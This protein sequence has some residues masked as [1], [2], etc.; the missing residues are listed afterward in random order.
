MFDYFKPKEFF[1][2]KIRFVYDGI[3]YSGDGVLFWDPTDGFHVAV[4]IKREKGERQVQV[5]LRSLTFEASTTLYLRMKNGSHVILP[6]YF[7]R[8]QNLHRGFL[9]E[10]ARRAIII[11]RVPPTVANVWHGS[12]LY[13]LSGKITLPD[14]VSTEFKID[15]SEP[16]RRVSLEGIHHNS[17]TGFQVYGY[18]KDD[19]YLDVSWIMPVNDWTKS[20]CWRYARGLQH[21][22]SVLAGQSIEL[23]YREVYRANRRYREV[24]LNQS[25]IDLGII[26]R[27]FDYD[28]LDR[29]D[30][31]NLAE[32]FTCGGETAEYARR[33]F[34]QMADASKQRSNAGKELLISTILEA[35]LRSIYN[36]PFDPNKNKKE[37]KFLINYYLKQFRTDYLVGSNDSKRRWKQIT[38]NVNSVYEILRHRNAHPDWKSTING[39][40]SKPELE[41]VTDNI[42]YLSRFYGFMIMGL[43]GIKYDTPKFPAPTNEWE[44]LITIRSG[45]S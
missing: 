1:I 4:N 35:V 36:R 43:A 13:E 16:R 19:K 25:P 2:R 14:P 12:A 37:N 11:D 10:N 26:F 42:I 44:P 21:S 23:K 28:I 24:V 17:D 15:N 20:E 9:S 27:P 18:Q 45:N 33:I 22:I 29:E 30:V 5:E 34:Y 6:I 38:N 8:V 32:F 39:S 40:Y 31:I 41:K 7:P 3:S